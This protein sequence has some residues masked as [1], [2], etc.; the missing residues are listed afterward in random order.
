MLL[1]KSSLLFSFNSAA[2]ALLETLIAISG[3]LL[4][5][6]M[7]LK[8]PGSAPNY[9][10]INFTS[11]WRLGNLNKL[12]FLLSGPFIQS[13]SLITYFFPLHLSVMENIKQRYGKRSLEMMLW[14]VGWVWYIRPVKI[15]HILCLYKTCHWRLNLKLI[16]LGKVLNSYNCLYSCRLTSGKCLI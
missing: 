11:Q 2:P 4:K 1:S 15:Y 7:W 13:V 9:C 12:H 5:L 3:A 10:H 14:R 8:T 16:L 6:L